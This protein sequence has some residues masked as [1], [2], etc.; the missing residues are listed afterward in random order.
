MLVV[1]AL[2]STMLFADGDHSV[3]GARFAGMAGSSAVFHD[4]W[5]VFGNQAGLAG[6]H[7]TSLGI[8]YENRFLM[9]ETGY[10]AFAFQ[11]PVAFG[12]LGIG[13]SHFGYSE[14]NENKFAIA[15]AQQL[16][17]RIAMGV[18]ADYFM[19]H[20]PGLYG[21]LHAFSFE[22]GI[23]VQASERLRFGAHVS[24][25]WP[26]QIIGVQ[27]QYLPAVLKAGM[28]YSF[29]KNLIVTV[30]AEKNLHLEKPVFRAGV[31]YQSDRHYSL[32]LGIANQ[33]VLFAVGFGYKF[34][35][36]HIDMGYGYHQV[37]GSSPVI[38]LN[39]VF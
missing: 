6:L 3:A 38:T 26:I 23:M 24:N 22:I 37:L 18:Q 36:F 39:Y 32:R 11:T 29:N 5:S 19:I 34:N 31:E 8:S 16:F 4:T 12:N 28:G 25:P 7:T 27:G 30:E 13:Y 14:Y 35:A 21:N 9:K 10:G 17:K 15:W 2:C 20:Q 1:L 33:P